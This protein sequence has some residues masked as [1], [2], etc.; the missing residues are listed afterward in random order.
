[1]SPTTPRPPVVA[2]LGHVDHGKTTLLDYI[3][4]TALTEGEAGGITQKIGG[5]EISTGIK[6]YQQDKITFIDTPGHEAFSKLRARGATV[7]DIALL[8]VDV[9]DSLKPQTIES[10]QHIQEAKL[11]F[12]VVVNKIDMPDTNPEKVYRDLLKYEVMI[13]QKGGQVPALAISAKTGVG[14]PDLLE[15][16]LLMAADLNLTFDKDAP[17]EIVIIETKKD[18]RGVVASCIIKNGTLRIGDTVFAQDKRVK[19]RSMVNDRGTMIREV[20]P[21]APFELLGFSAMPEVGTILTRIEQDA[22]PS[23]NQ[24]QVPTLGILESLNQE[25]QKKLSLVI[26][27]DAQ[28]SLEA[29]VTALSKQSNIQIVLQAVGD[30]HKSDVFLAKTAGAII[31]GFSVKPD[32]TVVDAAKQE[33]VIIKTYN[34]IYE[35]LDELSEVAQLIREK[36]IQEKTLKGEAKVL[37]NF[38]IDGEKV[39]GIKVTK[40]KINLGD[41]IELHRGTNLISTSKLISLRQRAKKVEEV[42]KDEEA[43]ILISPPL[44]ITIGDVIKSIL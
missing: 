32:A 35:A 17:P 43:G 44:D 15:S 24:T 34:I 12:I 38:I 37:A 26:K 22:V 25:T 30:I 28:G 21:C 27:A 16:I 14:V 18:R 36:E 6:G 31:I 39:Y 4:K 3:R 13:E 23:A 7:A 33:K 40:G 2:I 20:V 29:I 1:M 11:P 9:K 5:Y 19:V 42:K 41:S 8:I 10:I